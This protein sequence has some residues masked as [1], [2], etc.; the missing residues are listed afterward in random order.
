M[1]RT[2]NASEATKQAGHTRMELMASVALLIQCI[3]S[4]IQ[5][6]TLTESES[7]NGEESILGRARRALSAARGE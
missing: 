1:E 4:G 7:V 3:D 6:M 2:T 5:T